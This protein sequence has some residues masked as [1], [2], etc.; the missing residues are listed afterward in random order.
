MTARTTS[1][2]LTAAFGMACLTLA[3][4][5]S[6]T[7]ADVLSERPMTRMTWIDRA[8]VLSAAPGRDGGWINGR[9]PRR[10]RTCHRP[11]RNRHPWRR[12]R[13]PRRAPPRPRSPSR[14]A[15][16]PGGGRRG[17]RPGHGARG[18]QREAPPALRGGER[19][20]LLDEHGVADVG[21][22]VLVVGLE[23]RRQAD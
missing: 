1:P 5:T 16:G 19:P 10:R 21:V 6:P 15:A 22:V 2:F 8:P 9:L 7:P 13:S 23:L 14:R 11:P 4:I 3:T 17:S 18:D 20:R 12:P